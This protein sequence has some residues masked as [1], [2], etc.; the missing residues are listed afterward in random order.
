MILSFSMWFTVRKTLFNPYIVGFGL[1]LVFMAVVMG[2]GAGG[3]STAMPLHS[4]PL[5]C[6]G[7]F[8]SELAISHKEL[9]AMQP[10]TL[11]AAA[12]FLLGAGSV[13]LLRLFISQHR[14][15]HILLRARSKLAQLHDHLLQQFSSGILHP[16]IY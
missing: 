1:L 8:S 13:L 7:M 5:A 4:E 6:S 10:L 2:C 16:Q 9:G 11:L 14:L 12:L 3:I 15:V